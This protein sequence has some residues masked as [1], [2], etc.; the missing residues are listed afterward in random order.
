MHVLKRILVFFA[1]VTFQ[2][3][4][5]CA[6]AIKSGNCLGFSR[7]SALVSLIVTNRPILQ[8]GHR[9]MSLPYFSNILTDSGIFTLTIALPSF[10]LWRIWAILLCLSKGS[11]CSG[12][13]LRRGQYAP[14]FFPLQNIRGQY[15]PEWHVFK[16][17]IRTFTFYFTSGS[18][19]SV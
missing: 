16:A 8:H 7:L 13:T 11:I 2:P 1:S 6:L 14:D 12:I 9:F 19:G 3:G 5:G 4:A 17:Q 15:L 10:M 18:E